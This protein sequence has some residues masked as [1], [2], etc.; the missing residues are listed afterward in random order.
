MI[1][2]LTAGSTD[3][4]CLRNRKWFAYLRYKYLS[5]TYT[6]L[7]LILCIQFISQH[8]TELNLQQVAPTFG[9]GEDFS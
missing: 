4:H 9:G 3:F 1:F 2:A 8:N 5:E 7:H 6:I